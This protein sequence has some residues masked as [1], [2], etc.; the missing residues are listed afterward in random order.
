MVYPA[1]LLMPAPHPQILATKMLHALRAFFLRFRTPRLGSPEAPYHF[2]VPL[3]QVLAS[4]PSAVLAAV[5]SD[6]ETVCCKYILDN[7]SVVEVHSS[8][9]HHAHDSSRPPPPPP[10]RKLLN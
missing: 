2:T 6:R 4:A 10:P 3:D 8:E 1:N 7:G 5:L 9:C